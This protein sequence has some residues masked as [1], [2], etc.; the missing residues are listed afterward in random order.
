MAVDDGRRNGDSGPV[1]IA[2]IP[3][4]GARLHSDPCQP[5]ECG[6]QIAFGAQQRRARSAEFRAGMPGGTSVGAPDWAGV[7]AAGAAAGKTALQGHSVIY[8]GGYA[9]NLRDITNGTCGTDCTAGSGYDLVTGLGSL[10]NYPGG[11]PIDGVTLHTYIQI[12][13]FAAPLSGPFDEGVETRVLRCRR[14]L[15]GS[16]AERI[17]DARF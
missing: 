14:S 7:L 17:N 2:V 4:F 3:E 15:A 12:K 5:V 10:V 6:G 9:T 16:R 11:S 13:A 8:S 1:E